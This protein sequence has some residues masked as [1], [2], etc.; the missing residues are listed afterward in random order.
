M[1]LALK[2]SILLRE[3]KKTITHY[4]HLTALGTQEKLLKVGQNQDLLRIRIEL[5]VS[6]GICMSDIQCLKALRSLFE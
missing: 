5:L 2:L 3:L 6:I 4:M 1:F